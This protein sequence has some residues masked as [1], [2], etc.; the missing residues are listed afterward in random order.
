MQ[1]EVPQYGVEDTS[2]RAAGG[3]DGI[4]RL[5]D[6]FYLQMDTLEEARTIRAMHPED[7]SG[8]A[9]KLARFYVAGWADRSYIVRNMA[10]FIF[11]RPISPLI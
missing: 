8:S 10:Q 11:P 4:F 2:F 7:I 1:Q 3:Q 5:V 9:D 6:E